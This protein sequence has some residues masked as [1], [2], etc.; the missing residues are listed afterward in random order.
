MQ[1]YERKF[2]DVTEGGHRQ[3]MALTPLWS[4]DPH[5]RYKRSSHHPVHLL[6]AFRLSASPL[7]R[8]DECRPIIS[9]AGV[10]VRTIC[11]HCLL[12]WNA[13]PNRHILLYCSTFT[14]IRTSRLP[15]IIAAHVACLSLLDPNRNLSTN[16][17]NDGELLM[18]IL[19]RR[20]AGMLDNPDSSSVLVPRHERSTD[21]AILH[22][23]AIGLH[24]Q[25]TA[26]ASWMLAAMIKT[27]SNILK[28]RGLNP[29]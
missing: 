18:A 22:T 24:Q 6:T 16:P 27:R 10:A 26:R 20:P 28:R 21:V 5:L 1:I 25:V 14:A 23:K 4:L 13:G 29:A 2:P 19:G 3:L 12:E 17:P 8:D 11:P 9:S 15:A 7:Q